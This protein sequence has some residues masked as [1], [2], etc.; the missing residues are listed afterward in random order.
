[1]IVYLKVKKFLNPNFTLSNMEELLMFIK[2]IYISCR[3]GIL[4]VTEYNFK[5]SF[6]DLKVLIGKKLSSI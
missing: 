2:K 6:S 4:V 5:K 3:G 1:M